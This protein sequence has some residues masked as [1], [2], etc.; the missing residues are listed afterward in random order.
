MAESK[1]KVY[2]V[3]DLASSKTFAEDRD[4]VT[5][6]LDHNKQYSIEDAKKVIALFKKTPVK[7]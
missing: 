3:D 2:S 5:A 7:E 4:I 6:L 1:N